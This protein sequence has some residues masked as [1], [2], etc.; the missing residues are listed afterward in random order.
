MEPAPKIAVVIPT[1]DREGRLSMALEALREQ[2]L[3][4]EAFEVFV[5][6]DSSQRGPLA[7]PPDDLRV[8]CLTHTG[9]SGPTAKRNLGWRATTAPLVAFTDDDCR[10][11]PDWLEH[12]L[13]AAGDGVFIPGRTEADPEELHL[14]RG[15]ARS[16]VVIGPSPWYP[17][18]NIAYPRGML[19]RLTGFDESFYFGGE[20]TDLALRALAAGARA[21]YVD[22]ALV[23]HAVIPRDLVGALREAVA[24]PSLPLLIARHPAQR[25]HL[26]L[27]VF[28]NRSHALLVPPIA[29]IGLLRRRPAIA[30]AAWLPY[31][32]HHASGALGRPSP[33]A[34]LAR[35]TL[36]MPAIT[37][38]ELAETASM[39]KGAVAHRVFVA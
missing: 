37:L 35:L 22:E 21:R 25:R 7:A 3:G 4:R 26:Y 1:R 38:I 36:R 19:E 30:L 39:V 9:T 2:T 10:P 17:C 27:R 24:W 12:L 34:G 15:L 33:V 14:L 32:A 13:A 31:L 20:D 8:T 11:A 16:R 6:R 23:W 18:C 29:G 5:V 28:R